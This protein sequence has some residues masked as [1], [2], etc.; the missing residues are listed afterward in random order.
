MSASAEPTRPDV[1]RQLQMAVGKMA[2]IT[3]AVLVVTYGNGTIG[4]Y[5]TPDQNEALIMVTG[6]EI[7][8][9]RIIERMG[10]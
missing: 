3:G 8:K 4:H 1:L 10:Y 2:P 7:E 6:L 9:K 5:S